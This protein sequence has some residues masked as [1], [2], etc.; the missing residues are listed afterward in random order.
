MR[1]GVGS[2]VVS[3]VR[4]KK[5]IEGVA[6]FHNK[7]YVPCFTGYSHLCLST[8]GGPLGV[9]TLVPSFD[10]TLPRHSHANLQEGMSMEER[11]SPCHLKGLK[12][13]HM[14][15]ESQEWEDFNTQ[16]LLLLCVTTNNEGTQ[17]SKTQHR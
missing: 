14:E 10:C 16:G 9:D 4:N 11:T 8:M 1:A 17:G 7:R 12:Y 3:L 13:L 15:V 6:C 5:N 2:F